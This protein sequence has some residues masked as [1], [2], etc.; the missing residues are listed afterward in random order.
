M[1]NRPFTRERN[2]RLTG[3]G[4]PCAADLSIGAL[5]KG[6]RIMK[7]LLLLGTMLICGSAAAAQ[8]GAPADQCPSAAL[9]VIERT[10]VATL[11]R[12]SEDSAVI[13]IDVAASLPNGQAL[14]YAFSA[15]SGTI[16]SDGSRATWTV[17]G[18]GPFT[19]SVEVTAANYP[20]T[21]HAHFTYL[22]DRPPSE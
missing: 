2:D 12:N 8:D 18:A 3:R 10:D 14:T 4:S 22:M 13:Q 19:A 6:V 9:P 20:C 15:H 11:E 17:A 21:S 7:R 16:T 5:D 1:S